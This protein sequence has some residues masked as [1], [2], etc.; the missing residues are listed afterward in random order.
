MR[1]YEGM[2]SGRVSGA[3]LAPRGVD[4]AATRG[5]C[6]SDPISVRCPVLYDDG[7]VGEARLEWNP[8]QDGGYFTYDSDGTVLLDPPGVE[9]EDDPH[10]QDC[11]AALATLEKSHGDAPVR[12]IWSCIRVAGGSEW[13]RWRN[14]RLERSL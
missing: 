1:K 5:H 3:A 7:T 12:G 9:R 11:P 8:T 4:V 6:G 13:Y 10:I 14:G 2:I